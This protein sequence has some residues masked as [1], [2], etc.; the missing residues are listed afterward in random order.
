ME[1]LVAYTS[2]YEWPVTGCRHSE[3][4]E[5]GFMPQPYSSNNLDKHFP[6]EKPQNQ[7]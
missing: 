5:M 2:L 3:I 6:S 4:H 1:N 7:L